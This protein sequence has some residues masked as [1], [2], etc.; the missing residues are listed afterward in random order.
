M[1]WSNIAE[2]L[3]SRVK[4]EWTGSHGVFRNGLIGK[5]NMPSDLAGHFG[6]QIC[7]SL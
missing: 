3:C 2:G 4:S 7:A 5:P 6:H 1:P